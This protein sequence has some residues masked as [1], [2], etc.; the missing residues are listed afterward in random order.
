MDVQAIIARLERSPAA[1]SALLAGVPEPEARF[2]PPDGAWSMLEVVN[3]LADEDRDDFRLRLKSTLDSPTSPW[4]PIEPVG[5][6]IKRKYNEQDLRESLAR[7]EH[8]RAESVGWLKGLANQDWN[9]AH[10]HP[11]FGP[12]S[13]GDLLVA[14]AAHD[15]LH[16]RQIAKRLFELAARDGE[17]D[18]FKSRYAGEWTA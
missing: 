11:K 2:K 18:G 16:I 13:A 14:W 6:A 4:P 15:A 8:E 5:W 10:Q 17:A 7:F 1:L 3:H 9:S 12:I